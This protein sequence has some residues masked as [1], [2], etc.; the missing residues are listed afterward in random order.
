MYSVGKN[1]PRVGGFWGTR[2]GAF[3]GGG[4]LWEG[5][6]FLPGPGL[7][8]SSPLLTPS[9]LTQVI[10]GPLQEYLSQQRGYMYSIIIGY[11]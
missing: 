1:F 7:T 9:A 5:T 6:L 3:W 11:P 10:T 4:G 8:D 2:G